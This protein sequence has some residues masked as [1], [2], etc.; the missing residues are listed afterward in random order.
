MKNFLGLNISTFYR[1]VKPKL[2]EKQKK[3]KRKKKK[4]KGY[5]L[6]LSKGNEEEADLDVVEVVEEVDSVGVAD[7]DKKF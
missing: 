1:N 2:S 4:K 6:G 5:L 7:K 3:K